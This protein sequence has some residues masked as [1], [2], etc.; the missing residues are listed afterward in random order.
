LALCSSHIQRDTITK[1]IK[2]MKIIGEK[3]KA[4]NAIV[5]AIS[6]FRF[7]FDKVGIKGSYHNDP[8]WINILHAPIYRAIGY[9]VY[10][11]GFSISVDFELREINIENNN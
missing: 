3:T 7:N 10:Y 4:V 5:N 1:N 8:I 2:D 9:K 6:A 11:R